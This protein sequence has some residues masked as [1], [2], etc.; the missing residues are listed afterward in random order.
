MAE[1]T[2]SEAA[3]RFATNLK[4]EIRSSAQAEVNRFVR[5]YGAGRPLSELRGHEVSLY[6]DVLGAATTEANRRANQVRAFLAYLKKEG[7]LAVNLAPHLRLRK[8]TQMRTGAADP[9]QTT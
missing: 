2:L 1:I 7:L 8:A 4:D 5:W 6:A 9:Q 3:T